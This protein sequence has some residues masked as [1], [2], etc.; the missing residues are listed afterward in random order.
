LPTVDRFLLEAAIMEVRRVSA[1]LRDAL[2]LPV[3]QRVLRRLLEV[4]ELYDFDDGQV[5]PISQ[6][7]IAALAGA[8]RQTTNRI[9]AAAQTAGAIRLRRGS[10]EV[11]DIDALQKRAR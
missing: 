1:M 9:L 6:A 2:Y 3:E 8:A 11:L 10:I 7:D 4:A 5:I